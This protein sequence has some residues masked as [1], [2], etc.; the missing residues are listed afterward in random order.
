MLASRQENLQVSPN[1]VETDEDYLL[2]KM[3]YQFLILKSYQYDL[4]VDHNVI[5]G[6]YLHS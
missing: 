2:L 5:E 1:D 4:T 6:D 3:S